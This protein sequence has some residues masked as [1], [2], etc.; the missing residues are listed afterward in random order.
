MFAQHYMTK[1]YQK[2]KEDTA[3]PSQGNFFL[4]RF[5]PRCLQASAKQDIEERGEAAK[6]VGAP[7]SRRLSSRA[8]GPRSEA[9]SDNFAAGQTKTQT[10]KNTR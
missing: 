5:C 6:A 4:R 3:R 9:K 1:I 2:G 10:E 7:Q 8:G